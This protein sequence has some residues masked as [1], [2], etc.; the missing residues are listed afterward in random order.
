M[1]LLLKKI[2][3]LLCFT[4]FGGVVFAQADDPKEKVKTILAGKEA[5]TVKIMAL[6]DQ[7]FPLA[8]SGDSAAL[9][10]TTAIYKMLGNNYSKSYIKFRSMANNTCGICF[11]Y[12]GKYDSANY[13]YNQSLELGKKYDDKL[14][15]AKGYNNLGNVSQYTADFEKAVTYNYKAL[16]LFEAAKDSA[17]MAGAYGNLAN[18]YTRLKQFSKATE[19]CQ[20]AISFATRRNDKRLLANSYN[21]LATIY[22]EQDKDSLEFVYAVKAYNVYIEIKNIK[23]LS[24][25]TTNLTEIY[26]NRNNFDSAQ[27][28][29][30]LGIKYSKQIDDGQN[31]GTLYNALGISYKKQNKI[32]EAQMAFDSVVFY[33]QQTGDK[34]ILSKAYNSKAEIFYQEGNFKAGYENLEKY[35]ILNDSIFNT[36]MQSSIAEMQ[37]KYETAKKEQK[38]Q[39]QQ[40]QLTKKN[41]WIG[42][43][44]G[45]LL[46][47]GLLGFS[48]YRS[49]KLQQAKKLQSEIMLQQDM[50]TKAVIEAEENERKRIA[51]DLHDGVGQIMSA[52]KMNLS[53][54]ESRLNFGN[55]EDKI[56]FEKIVNLVDESCKEVRTVSHNMMPNALL[57]SGLSSAVKEFIDK[58]DNRVLKV[59]L[60]SEGLNE[61]LDSN[62]ET[63]L[64]RVIQECVNNVIKHSGANELDI[65]LIK[66]TDGIAATIEDNGK[67]FAVAEKAKADGIGLKN[68]KTR[69]EYLKGTVDFDSFP[70]KGTLVAIHVPLGA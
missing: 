20:Q 66:D 70:G 69:I 68:I 67:G 55:N 52:A 21:T 5:D 25:T 17:G 43:A 7:G 1:L 4:F 32:A 53:S 57:K 56:A 3:S 22:G 48:F 45:L 19:L 14:I 64:Y 34:L 37:T 62:V 12:S 61:R 18:N 58:I 9:V 42:G 2:T 24:S 65:S 8:L 15:M 16:E 49:N 28:Y 29:A 39:Q 44:A 38:I 63:V 10:Y 27:K 47:G 51:G 13:Y 31:L 46:L 50:A 54:I 36:N 23:G 30:L 40:F 35:T 26:T 11:M 33:A 6:M 60:Y 41:Y 59:N